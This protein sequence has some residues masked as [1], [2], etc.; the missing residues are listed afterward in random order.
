MNKDDVFIDSVA[1]LKDKLKQEHSI[2]VKPALVKDVLKRDLRMRYKLVK[3]ISWFE[4]SIKSKILRQQFAL[5]FL[6]IDLEKK[7]ILNI[8][9][10]ALG[11][12]DFRRRKWRPHRHTNSVAKLAIAPRVSM[13]VGLDT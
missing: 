1:S 3:P 7:V 13:I 4:N 2:D 11:H 5:A 10:T 8:D 9:E 12:S 6:E